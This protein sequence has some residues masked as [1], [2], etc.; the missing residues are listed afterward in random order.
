MAFPVVEANGT[1]LGV[2]D[3]EL[4]N[5]ELLGVARQAFDEIFSLTGV[6]ATAGRNIWSGF[7]DRFPWLMC[8]VGGGLMCALLAS[9][10]EQLLATF[11]ILSLFVPVVLALGE[12]VSIQTLTLTLQALHGDKTD[13]KQFLRSVRR[14]LGVATLLGLGCGLLVGG[15]AWLWKA[16]DVMAFAI[17]GAIWLS[18]ITAALV[19]LTLPTLIHSVKGNAHIAA[20]P[21][22]PGDG[23]SR[24]TPILFSGSDLVGQPLVAAERA[25]PRCGRFPLSAPSRMVLRR[26]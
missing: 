12:S 5:D 1:L 21:I 20:G 7:R 11:V 13:W 16:H 18:M 19:G 3:I 15:T 2:V 22:G 9:R 6:H 24:D 10:Y 14:E 26:R 8:N 4:F 17:G 25:T 23:G